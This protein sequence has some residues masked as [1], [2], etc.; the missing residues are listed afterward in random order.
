MKNDE[1]LFIEDILTLCKKH[2]FSI[3]HEDEFGAFEIHNYDEHYSDWLRHA[4]IAIP[5]SQRGPQ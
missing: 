1:A 3:G 4:H 5:A 2:G